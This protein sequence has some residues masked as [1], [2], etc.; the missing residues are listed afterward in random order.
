MRR[1]LVARVGVLTLVG[2]S[3]GLVYAGV[4]AVRPAPPAVSTG[5]PV[6]P[7][8]SVERPRETATPAEP[9]GFAFRL[10]TGQAAS[11][12]CAEARGVVRQVRRSL[13]YTPHE[14]SPGALA[15]ATADWL[16][17]HGLWSAAPDSP[18]PAALNGVAPSLLEELERRTGPCPASRSVGASLVEWTSDLGRRFDGA[19]RKAQPGA[20]GRVDDKVFDG[21]FDEEGRPAREVAVAMGQQAGRLE[22]DVGPSIVSYIEAARTRFFPPLD[23]EG[24]AGVVRA[25]TVRAYI[26]IVDPH[27]AWAPTDEEASIYDVDLDPEPPQRLWEEGTRTAVGV[28]IDSGPLEPLEVGDLVLSVAG[29]TTAG[30]SLEQLDQLM[31]ATTD[32]PEPATLAVLRRGELRT[33]EL[34]APGAAPPTARG[35]DAATELPAFRIPYGSGTALVVEVHEVRSDLGDTLAEAVQR[36]TARGPVAGVLLDLR[37]D[38][39][40]STEGAIA[41]LGLF[42]P[43]AP[44]FPMARQDGSIEVDRAPEPPVQD[45]WAGPIATLVD[46]DTASAAEMIA[47]ALLA[48]HRGAVVGEGTF[49]KGCAQEYLDDPSRTGVLRLTTLLYALPDGSPVQRVGLEPSLLLPTDETAGDPTRDARVR[50]A[51]EPNAPPTW[52]GPD[53]RDPAR[54]SANPI[55]WPAHGGVVGPCRDA[56][57][58]QALRALGVAGRH[59]TATAS[60]SPPAG[61]R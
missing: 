22:R 34:P 26:Q 29:V 49:G 33:L 52:R 45:R 6:A 21:V 42:L 1:S 46:R 8:A 50:E 51:D 20:S 7:D 18:V 11:L 48:Y 9:G 25:A 19:R 28:R 54:V 58:C 44:L 35:D 43:G 23:A 17:P 60:P 10:P 30:L 5:V 53:V 36:E 55:G 24:W 37:D 12:T 14:V 41:A 39:G 61:H 32:A 16:D 3:I 31:Y 38:G 4:G 27:G 2:V 15:T 47:G 13:A 57:V 56:R 59:A 40:G